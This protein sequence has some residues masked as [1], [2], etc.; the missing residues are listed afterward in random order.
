[1]PLQHTKCSPLS[2]LQGESESEQDSS[3]LERLQIRGSNPETNCFVAREKKKHL[4]E[5]QFRSLKKWHCW[6]QALFV[7]F[8]P[9]NIAW[10][11][12][13]RDAPRYSSEVFHKSFSVFYTVLFSQRNICCSLVLLTLLFSQSRCLPSAQFC[14]LWQNTK[15]IVIHSHF[16]S[17]QDYD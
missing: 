1:M 17:K 13:G 2:S 7:I 12:R 3:P 14:P 15:H 10:C 8:V 16:Q 6:N 4:V 11:Q 9:L 5:F